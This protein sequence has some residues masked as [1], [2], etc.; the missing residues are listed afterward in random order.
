V[1]LQISSVDVAIDLVDHV[2]RVQL[3]RVNAA[4]LVLCDLRSMYAVVDR[5]AV[6]VRAVARGGGLVS[7]LSESLR[8]TRRVGIPLF[9]RILLLVGIPGLPKVVNVDFVPMERAIEVRVASTTR[10]G[11]RTARRWEHR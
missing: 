3:A 10:A 9:T 5:D 11:H 7:L 8:R 1:N 2:C 6:E 4:I